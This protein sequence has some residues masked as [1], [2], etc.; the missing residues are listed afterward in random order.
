M[1]IRFNIRIFNVNQIQNTIIEI[2]EQHKESIIE[3]SKLYSSDRI[4]HDLID[5]NRRR[6][7]K[8]RIKRF[9]NTTWPTCLSLYLP[10]TISNPSHVPVANPFRLDYRES[11]KLPCNASQSPHKAD[12]SAKAILGQLLKW[13]DRFGNGRAVSSPA[14]H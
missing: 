8:E 10:C 2:I 6:K 5:S 11:Y 4:R 9:L 1:L 14:C 12:K 7:R 13:L 3:E